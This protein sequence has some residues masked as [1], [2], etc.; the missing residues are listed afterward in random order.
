MWMTQ[1]KNFYLS[2]SLS[3]SLSQPGINKKWL[4]HYDFYGNNSK[5]PK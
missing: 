4:F 1:I 2:L 5:V 3:L